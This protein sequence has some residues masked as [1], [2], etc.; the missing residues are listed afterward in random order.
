MN[1]GR[2]RAADLRFGIA[3]LT[4][5]LIGAALAGYRLGA[6]SLWLDE[7]YTW[8]FSRLGWS[9]LLQAARIDAVNPPAYYAFVK[10][11]A[12]STS[13]AGL[14][15]PSL[16]AQVGGIA[17]AA[18]LGYGLGGRPGALAAAAVWAVHPLTLWTAR[19][20]R[21]YALAA[22]WAVL[23]V[24]LFVRL[25]RRWSSGTAILAG[26]VLA[27]G[28]LT[29][30]FFFVLAASLLVLA[31]FDLRRSPLFFRGWALVTL[32]ALI[33]LTLWLTWFLTT[34]A[35]SLGIG[36]IRTPLARDLPLTLWNLVS[37]YSGVMD[38]AS[39]A[40]GVLVLIVIGIGLA[41]RSRRQG[42]L[43]VGSLL[44]AVG[45]VWIISQ[46]RAVYVDRYFVVLLP[47]VAAL[48]ALG[49]AEATRRWGKDGAGKFAVGF[50]AALAVV[51][52]LASAVGVHTAQKFQKEDWRALAAF[53]QNEGAR[54]EETVLSEPEI[55]LPLSYYSARS[56]LD[57]SQ[58]LAGECGPACWF[59]LRQPYTA[60]HALTQSVHEPD[61]APQPAPPQ[62]C[63]TEDGWA[64]PTGVGVRQMKCPAAGG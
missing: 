33:P 38:A 13:E 20:A 53:L 48:V 62:G 2:V 43:L 19:D 27:L 26:I 60:T 37:G 24:G 8:W 40:F 55:T 21:P 35:P 34:G 47:F 28:L 10:L 56:P 18:L 41:G 1:L 36:W 14:R 4:T 12:T 3:L 46:R 57:V 7:T 22:A 63:Q 50:A 11:L 42:V 44:L 5:L 32:A 9:G 61:R 25:Q 52:A 15:F 29:H 54:L 16:A 31:A 30:Y 23:A 49:A 59:I 17:A 45:A 51:V 6:Q 58:H 64:S 39:T